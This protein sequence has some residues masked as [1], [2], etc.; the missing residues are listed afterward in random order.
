MGACG[1]ESGDA[2]PAAFAEGRRRTPDRNRTVEHSG[3]TVRG[4]AA[5]PE[6]DRR[7]HL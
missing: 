7:L 3:P 6:V 1:L 2:A 4:R 5:E